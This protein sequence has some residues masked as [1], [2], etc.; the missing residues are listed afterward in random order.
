VFPNFN[1]P[2]SRSDALKAGDELQDFVLLETSN[3]GPP[4][5]QQVSTHVNGESTSFEKRHST[6]V[7]NRLGPDRASGGKN[8]D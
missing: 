2:D 4:P 7:K 1:V 8:R 5:A 3:F 6:H